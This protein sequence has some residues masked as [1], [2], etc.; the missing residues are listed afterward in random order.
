MVIWRAGETKKEKAAKVHTKKADY[1]AEGKKPE[2]KE[3]QGVLLLVSI[4]AD[5]R[6]E[7]AIIL[8]TTPKSGETWQSQRR[9]QKGGK[10]SQALRG[11]PSLGVSFRINQ[12]NC[13]LGAGE[14]AAKKVPA[15]SCLNC[16]PTEEGSRDHGVS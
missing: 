11:K 2:Q 3:D 5:R 12:T 13:L 1:M 8:S 4:E 7:N 14:N 16:G 9:I 15:E 10:G 6:Q